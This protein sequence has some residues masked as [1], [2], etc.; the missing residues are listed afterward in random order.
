MPIWLPT[1]LSR[2]RLRGVKDDHPGAATFK[3]PR[4]RS[5]ARS[6]EEAWTVNPLRSPVTPARRLQRTSL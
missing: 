5:P 4:M 1:V 6:G 3:M 2:V